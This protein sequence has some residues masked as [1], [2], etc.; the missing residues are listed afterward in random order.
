MSKDKT[1]AIALILIL[2][3]TSMLI[4]F[5]IANAQAWMPVMNLPG[6][7]ITYVLL[8]PGIEGVDIDLNGPTIEIANVTLWVMYPGRTVWTYIGGWPTSG[9]DLDVYDFDFNETGDFQMRWRVPPQDTIPANPAD[10][11]GYWNSNYPDF[12]NSDT[13]QA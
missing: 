10:P 11:D 2:T 12:F 4:A 8:L 1:A 3:L 6:G 7:D 5:P 13:I 9:S